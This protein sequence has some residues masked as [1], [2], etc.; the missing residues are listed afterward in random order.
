M[1]LG[2]KLF[3]TPNLF[4]WVLDDGN[5]LKKCKSCGELRFTQENEN[6]PFYCS[7]CGTKNGYDWEG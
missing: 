4:M 6:S 5:T 7:A 3:L 2:H 1:V